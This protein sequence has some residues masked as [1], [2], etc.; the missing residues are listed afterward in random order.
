MPKVVLTASQREA[1]KNAYRQREFVRIL[2]EMKIDGIS[3][4]SIAYDMGVSPAT[5]CDRK[6]DTGTMSLNA[7]R[8]F[9]E[10]A[11]LTDEQILRLVRG[12]KS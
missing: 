2:L 7:L 12:K 3:Q 6:K 5:I 1:E 11:N 8:R 10:V 9:V 4:Q